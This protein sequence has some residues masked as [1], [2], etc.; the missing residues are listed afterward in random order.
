M[1]NLVEARRLLGLSD[2]AVL[3]VRRLLDIT[4]DD[5]G[6]SLVCYREARQRAELLETY[7]RELAGALRAVEREAREREEVNRGA[8]RLG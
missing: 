3:R 7:A 8:S 5:T 1:E 4:G 6:R 2:D